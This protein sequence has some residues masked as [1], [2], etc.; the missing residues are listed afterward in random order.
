MSY[1]FIGNIQG[2]CMPFTKNL[3]KETTPGNVLGTPGF[4]TCGDGY[5]NINGKCQ[6]TLFPTECNGYQFD[7]NCKNYLKDNLDGCGS[8]L[9]GVPNL[10]LKKG[11]CIG[12]D[13]YANRPMDPMTVLDSKQL[14]EKGYDALSKGYNNVDATSEGNYF[15]YG[16]AY[17][18]ANCGKDCSKYAYRN[19]CLRDF[20]QIQSGIMKYIK[21]KYSILSNDE[22]TRIF[23]EVYGTCTS[24]NVKLC[25]AAELKRVQQIKDEIIR[26]PLKNL[27]KQKLNE[28]SK[29]LAQQEQYLH[30]GGQ[31]VMMGEFVFFPMSWLSVATIVNT[32]M[33]VVQMTAPGSSFYT[34]KHFFYDQGKIDEFFGSGSGSCNATV[35]NYIPHT[36]LNNPSGEYNYIPIEN[37]PNELQYEG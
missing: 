15:V 25:Y 8:D 30:E 9:L 21:D 22:K 1:N 31:A 6:Y 18:D 19:C 16:N 36:T 14:Y 13:L 37:I 3:M 11:D 29:L 20:I 23:N 17:P 10:K 35:Q 32:D 12:L 2:P 33:K 28:L 5:A 7:T 4:S 24:G 26:V 27:N 34:Y